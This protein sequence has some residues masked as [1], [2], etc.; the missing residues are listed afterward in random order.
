M[1]EFLLKRGDSTH[2][3]SSRYRDGD[4]VIVRPDGW[5]WSVAELPNVVKRPD[6]NFRTVENLDQSDVEWFVRVNETDDL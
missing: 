6:L 4:I 3:R 5:E 1:V 2:F